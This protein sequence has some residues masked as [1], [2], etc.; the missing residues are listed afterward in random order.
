MV[1]GTFDIFHEGHKNFLK[2]AKRCGDWLIVVVAR[3]KTVSEVK[4]L[5]PKNN[6]KKRLKTIKKSKLANKVVSG[7]F[8]D[9]Y[10]IIEKY[11]P[12]IICL[13]YDQFHFTDNLKEILAKRGLK[14]IQI[15]RLKAFKPEKYKSSK[16]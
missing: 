6:E 3:D 2:Q 5:W 12:E 14:N 1:F 4:G 16:L 13:G 7:Y 15:I 8:R 9:K 11:K 10:K